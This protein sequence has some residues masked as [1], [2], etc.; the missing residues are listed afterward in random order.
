MQRAGYTMSGSAPTKGGRYK[1]WWIH[2]KHRRVESIYSPDK[3]V[4]ITA[5]HP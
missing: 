2:N 3:T 1:I 5:Y 4:V